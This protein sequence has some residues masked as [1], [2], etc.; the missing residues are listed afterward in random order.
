MKDY[1][2]LLYFDEQTNL[3][4]QKMINVAADACGSRRMFEP[5]LIP[6]H[7]TV[8]YFTADNPDVAMKII[9][10]KAQTLSADRIIWPALG[11]FPISTIYAAPVPN[12][13]LANLCNVF[14]TLLEGI[15]QPNGWYLPNSWMP[16]TT[17]AMELTREQYNQAF[18]AVSSVFTPLAGV[19]T[20]LSLVIC[21]P[22]E[23]LKTWT[24]GGSSKCMLKDLE[25]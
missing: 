8:C 7:I 23:E 14:N 17:L 10:E 25:K 4:L 9:D 18:T 6:P 5:A 12:E 19:A 2:V 21:E 24:L 13:Y 15:V 3:S 11:V 16:H 1:A 20:A 22:F